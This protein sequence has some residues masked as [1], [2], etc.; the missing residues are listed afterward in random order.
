M[1]LLTN[2]DVGPWQNSSWFSNKNSSNYNIRNDVG[3]TM[4]LG[5]RPNYN[6]EMLI[7]KNIL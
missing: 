5:E 4:D 6:I 7:I 3:R 1:P 2:G